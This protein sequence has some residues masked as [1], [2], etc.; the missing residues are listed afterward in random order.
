MLK[1]KPKSL[2]ELLAGQDSPLGNLASKALLRENLGNHLR[3]QLPPALTAGFL[4]CNLR[5]DTT[6]IVITTSPEWA[7]RLR[8]EKE[9]FIRLCAEYGTTVTSVKVR[10]GSG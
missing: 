9:L 4:H 7:S 3:K 2:S 1:K 10:V 5:D 6:L 8:F